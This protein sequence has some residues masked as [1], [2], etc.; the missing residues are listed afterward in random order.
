MEYIVL[1]EA[2][3]EK[4]GHHGLDFRLQS[5]NL[6]YFT[7]LAQPVANFFN[8]VKSPLNTSESPPYSLAAL[9]CQKV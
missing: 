9:Y 6:F 7:A 3:P 4:A 5:H 1:S 2:Y 8:C